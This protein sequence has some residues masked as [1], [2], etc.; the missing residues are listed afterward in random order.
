MSE[1]GPSE[2]ER[3]REANIARNKKLLADLGLDGGTKELVEKGSKKG[4]GRKITNEY[5][6]TFCYLGHL[7]YFLQIFRYS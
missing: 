2:Y 7:S 6:I 1:K 4:K 3:E 5:G